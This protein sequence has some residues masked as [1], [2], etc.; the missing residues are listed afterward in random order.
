[1][2]FSPADLPKN[3]QIKPNLSLQKKKKH[4]SNSV[5][6]EKK[7]KINMFELKV[8]AVPW[9]VQMIFRILNQADFPVG[10][11]NEVRKKYVVLSCNSCS[12]M[13]HF[14]DSF[15]I[16]AFHRKSQQSDGVFL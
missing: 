3:Y 2:F 11:R 12:S 10:S 9:M 4:V 13:R 14:N 16:K 8:S 5:F 1:M 6:K 15:R 7:L